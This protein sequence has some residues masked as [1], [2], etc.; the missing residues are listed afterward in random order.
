VLV[1]TSLFPREPG[2]KQGN[3]VLDQVEALA[4]CGVPLTILKVDSWDPLHLRKQSGL[5]PSAYSHAPFRMETAQVFSLPR[6]TLGAFAGPVRL[7][8]LSPILRRLIARDG[9]QVIHAHGELLAYPVVR[10]ARRMN[11]GSVITLH[12]IDPTPRLINSV[13]KRAQL[14]QTLEQ[15]NAVI[16]VGASLQ[17]YFSQF[18][19][20]THNFSVVPNGFRI[21]QGVS[22][23]GRVP[24][25]HPLRIVVV[26]NLHPNKGIDL[27]LR[28]LAASVGKLDAEMIIVGGGSEASSLRALARELRIEERVTFTGPL[29][30]PEAQS[31]IMAGDIFCLPSW[32]EAFGVAYLEAMALGKFTIG[33]RG[34]GPSDFIQHLKTGFLVEPRSVQSVADAFEWYMSHPQE[35]QAIARAA[36]PAATEGFTWKRN[37][38]RIIEIYQ[39]A[40]E[41]VTTIQPLPAN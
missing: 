20:S 30:H 10:L 17:T 13:R 6:Y 22:A 11:L 40:A 29:S 2:E 26:S 9:I 18:V 34:Q 16:S 38:A 32:R 15:A 41:G 31:E 25:R 21:Q 14:R 7:F 28:A 4:D 19:D 5:I 33:C 36:I 35:A 27:S 39:S 3:F 8:S 1:V 23:S 24:R 12:G 37:A